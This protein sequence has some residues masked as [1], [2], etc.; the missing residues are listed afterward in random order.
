M[1]SVV[2]AAYNEEGRIGE[3]LLR[4][5]RYFQET[6]RGHEIIVVDDGSRDNTGRIVS[7]LSAEIPNLRLIRYETNMGKGFALRTGVLA[8]R[9]DHVLLSDADLSTPIE[10]L[11]GLLRLLTHGKCDIAIGSR[12]LA[13]SRII[14]KQPWWRRGMG[15]IFNRIV[16]FAVLDEFR[17]TQC[18]FKLFPA[19]LARELFGV[20]RVNRFAF[21]VEI[22]ALARKKGYRVAEI[23]VRWKNAPGSK[24]NP[25]TDS[26]RMLFDLCRIRLMLGSVKVGRTPRSAPDGRL[27]PHPLPIPSTPPSATSLRPEA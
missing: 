6:G 7:D 18:G 3:S 22:L 17:D 19:D 13:M 20:A 16:R 1:I 24:V 15:K 21:D 5:A 14:R 26:M 9:G 2:I 27:V 25:L 10:E 12:A 4:I 11:T 8:S 23:P